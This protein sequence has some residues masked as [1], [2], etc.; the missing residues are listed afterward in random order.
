M[1]EHSVPTCPQ[2]G[3]DYIEVVPDDG[4][5][6][7]LEPSCIWSALYDAKP[8]STT[9]DA[10]VKAKPGAASQ[11]E[12]RVLIW[13]ASDKGAKL[14]GSDL[15]VARFLLD[16]C[17]ATTREAFPSERT[18]ASE[19]HLGRSTVQRA[20]EHLEAA[21]LIS[22]KSAWHLGTRHNVYTFLV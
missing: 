10:E 3:A 9:S 22:V 7:C 20:L 13:L 4:N 11:H 6:I 17:D 16:H 12:R 19:T 18:L 2:H 21:R 14:I 1:A 15:L 8:T 5:V